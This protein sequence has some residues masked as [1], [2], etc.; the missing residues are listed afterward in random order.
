MI[1]LLTA[2]LLL[3]AIAVTAAEAANLASVSCENPEMIS[4]M[5]NNIRN[6]RAEGGSPL[7]SH[8][9]HTS[10]ITKSKT[11]FR[12]RNKLICAISLQVQHAGTRSL[13]RLRYTF[14]QFS[15]GKLR[16]TVTSR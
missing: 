2:T 10:D 15:S 5:E 14:E 1:R 6:A 12:N 8:G 3:T 11:E 7:I 16:A 9:I 13:V 4:I